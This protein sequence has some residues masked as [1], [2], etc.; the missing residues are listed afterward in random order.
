[1]TRTTPKGLLRWFLRAPIWFYR[2]RLGWIFGKRFLMFTHTGRKSGRKIDTVVEVVFHDEEA[3][4]YFIASGWGEKAQ[5]LL[6]IARNP[7]I[8]VI[9]GRRQFHAVTTRLSR[10]TGAQ[11]LLAYAQKYPSA[12]KKLTR[13]MTG[14]ELP[15]D[16]EGVSQLAESVPIIAVDPLRS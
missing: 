7:E 2:N 15:A 8:D 10:E 14:A 6:N 5:W 4:R 11:A 3:D 16:F 9:V 12:F 13:L 1:M